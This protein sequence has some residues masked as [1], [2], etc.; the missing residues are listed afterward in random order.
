[1]KKIS[2]SGF[3]VAIHILLIQNDQILLLRRYNT[4][5]EDGNYSL[6]AGHV[7]AQESVIMAAIREAQEEVGIKIRP[8]NI[9]VCGI[10]HRK[11]E[12]ERFDFFVVV[13]K[14]EGLIQNCESNKC[15]HLMWS[16]RN[17]L[18]DNTIPY[19]RRAIELTFEISPN[20]MWYDEFGWNSFAYLEKDRVKDILTSR[21]I[22][23]ADMN[24]SDIFEDINLIISEIDTKLELNT[25]KKW[26]IDLKDLLIQNKIVIGTPI[27]KNM[28]LKHNIGVSA[29]SVL[30]PTI[31]QGNVDFGILFKELEEYLGR[32]IGIGLDLSDSASPETDIQKIDNFLFDLDSHLIRECKRPVAV[33]ITIKDNHPN[34]LEFIRVRI[35]KDFCRSRLN[36]SIW[37]TDNFFSDSNVNIQRA[38]AHSISISG[39]P[40]LLF[41]EKLDCNNV[42]PDYAY[43]STA[44]CAE[45][46]MSEYDAC[47]FSYLNISEFVRNG[48]SD[49]ID[50][51]GLSKATRII[52]R[53]LDNSIEYTLM[54]N[55]CHKESI[56]QKRR[57][58]IGI[59][60]FATALLKMGISYNSPKALEIA[61][62]VAENT[63]Y[64]SKLES[65]ELAKKRGRFPAYSNSKYLNKEW[66]RKKWAN[67]I[68][69]ER[70]MDLIEQIESCGLRN[71]TTIAFPPSGTSSQIAGVSA[72]FEPYLSFFIKYKEKKFV[73]KV[74]CDYIYTKYDKDSDELIA[75]ILRDE[76]DIDKYPEFIK[77]TQ[78]SP[79]VQLKMTSIFQTY[80]DESAS[81]TLN[82]SKHISED[83]IMKCIKDIYQ[84]GI[85]GISIF[86]ESCNEA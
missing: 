55:H 44:P 18:P 38:V 11:A 1:M 53:F 20:N 41:M 35:N 26:S 32:G 2:H 50:L 8:F 16:S 70:W 31:K 59:V 65:L 10:M 85:K 9:H 63:A 45:V 25:S 58:G 12:D 15:D 77:A 71:A 75:Q 34:L 48:D 47:H 43:I 33:M 21:G 23:S 42:T 30:R 5:Y 6:V 3:P 40:S 37:V 72:S 57:I 27:M 62:L 80:S 69:L 64:N 76:V 86:R 24:L 36:T 22:L 67:Y 49:Y 61:E 60:G 82:V 79:E 56:A 13:K 46:A 19:I 4:G 83:S 68:N 28:K 84:S 74:I 14:W 51:E 73:P 17:Q 7:E 29:C 54:S 78:I 66:M 81:K 39:E 52:V